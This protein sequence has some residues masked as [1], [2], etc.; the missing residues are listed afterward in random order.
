MNDIKPITLATGNRIFV[1]WSENIIA[2]MNAKQIILNRDFDDNLIYHLVITPTVNLS[3]ISESEVIILAPALIES[4]VIQ[5]FIF[6][7]KRN[8]TIIC[9]LPSEAI[10]QIRN[11]GWNILLIDIFAS[12][13]TG[14]KFASQNST[15]RIKGIFRITNFTDETSSIH[16]HQTHLTTEQ[17]VRRC[18]IQFTDFIQNALET[19]NF[20]PLFSVSRH[21]EE[22]YRQAFF[23]GHNQQESEYA[24][25]TG[26][27]LQKYLTQTL[28]ILNENYQTS[29]LLS[30]DYL[31]WDNGLSYM[32]YVTAGQQTSWQV[33][34]YVLSNHVCSTPNTLS[35]QHL[36]TPGDYGFLTCLYDHESFVD[37][38]VLIPFHK[39]LKLPFSLPDYFNQYHLTNFD[40]PPSNSSISQYPL[41]NIIQNYQIIHPNAA[42]LDDTFQ[43]YIVIRYDPAI[44]EFQIHDFFR[45]NNLRQYI[46]NLDQQNESSSQQI[47][48]VDRFPLPVLRETFTP[49]PYSNNNLSFQQNNNIVYNDMW[50]AHQLFWGPLQTYFFQK[51]LLTFH[52]PYGFWRYCGQHINIMTNTTNANNKQI[53]GSWLIVGISRNLFPRKGS[54]HFESIQALR[55]KK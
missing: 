50:L 37:P 3:Q 44:G 52:V 39:L 31:Q 30:L 6:S 26:I 36:T 1:P 20:H 13:Q 38:F 21:I 53:E 18:V 12:P 28:D 14:D 33:I 11:H 42:T 43:T 4:F 54:Q 19:T 47:P 8:G 25:P 23:G 32:H 10:L 29:I 17:H 55:L 7:S 5:E 41:Q 34:Q 49:L 35:Y 15:F 48:Y 27:I 46:Q 22:R 2:S 16:E 9:Y 24:Y 40:S 45:N 51:T